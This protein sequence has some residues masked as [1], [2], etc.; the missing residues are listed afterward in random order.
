[1]TRRRSVGSLVRRTNPRRSRRSMTPVTAPDVMPTRRASSPAV[2]GPVQ[3]STSR[4]SKSVPWMP[5][6]SAIA[7]AVQAPDRTAAST[8]AVECRQQLPAASRETCHR[9]P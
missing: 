8:L 4:H 3:S 9:F 7:L 5:A 1:M 6:R 2:I